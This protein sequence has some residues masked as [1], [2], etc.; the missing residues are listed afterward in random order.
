MGRTVCTI[1]AALALFVPLGLAPAH[2]QQA[3]P[4][5]AFLF[6]AWTGGL[7]PPPSQVSAE[8]CLAQ[9]TVIFTRD[10]VMRASLTDVL[11]VQRA[12]ETAR[13]TGGGVEIRLAPAAA[14]Q[15]AGGLGASEPQGFGCANPDE[16]TVKRLSQ[17]E[18]SFPGCSEFPFP[19][20]RCPAG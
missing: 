19:L 2:A 1:V 13:G 4:P 12:I 17:N 18:I 10:D 16:L 9:P 5:H 6:G 15:Q 8:A 20:V 7:F 3:P 14:P 11:Y